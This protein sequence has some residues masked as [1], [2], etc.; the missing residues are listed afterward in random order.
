M[1]G[2]FR[3]KWHYICSSSSASALEYMQNFKYFK[4]SKISIFWE[5]RMKKWFATEVFKAH[6]KEHVFLHRLVYCLLNLVAYLF[7][8]MIP[9]EF[10]LLFWEIQVFVT[11]TFYGQIVFCK[12][13]DHSLVLFRCKNWVEWFFEKL[14]WTSQSKDIERNVKSGRFAMQ[15]IVGFVHQGGTL[16]S[17]W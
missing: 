15:N 5:F 16:D 8:H 9:N 14:I 2:Y 10:S 1:L 7:L 3:I 4:N 17:F 13:F 6:S 11:M 12:T